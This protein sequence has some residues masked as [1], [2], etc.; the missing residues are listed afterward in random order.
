MSPAAKTLIIIGSLFIL[1]GLGLAYFNKIPGIGKL[2]GDIFV[3]GKHGSF[4]F[5]L[6]T[7]LILSLFLNIIAG[8]LLET[9]WHLQSCYLLTIN[10]V[11]GGFITNK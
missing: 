7:C 8:G 1:T 5:P 9:V 11:E 6:M 10:G 3:K 4:Y 2:P